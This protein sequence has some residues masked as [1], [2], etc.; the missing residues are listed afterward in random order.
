MQRK[1]VPDVVERKKVTSVVTGD[2]V[3]SAAKL[4]GASKNSLFFRGRLESA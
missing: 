2:S 1:I 3:I 4:M